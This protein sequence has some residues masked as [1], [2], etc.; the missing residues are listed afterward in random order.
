HK[1]LQNRAGENNCF[2]NVTVQ[3]LWHLDSF[4]AAVRGMEATADVREISIDDMITIVNSLFAQYEYYEGSAVPPTELRKRL[5]SMDPERYSLGGLADATEALYS[6]LSQ[7]HIDSCRHA[8]LPG[9]VVTENDECTPS[10]LAHSIFGGVFVEQFSCSACRATSEPQVMKRL[11]HYI[12]ADEVGSIFDAAPS[13]PSFSSV[14][15]Y[16]LRPVAHECPSRASTQRCQGEGKASLSCL[17]PPRVLAFCISWAEER[18]S[19]DKLS[20]FI[21]SIDIELSVSDVFPYG[22]FVDD[23]FHGRATHELCGL[24]CFYGMHYICF[25]RDSSSSS[26][27][28]LFDDARVRV[29]G[30]WGD[31]KE[32]C[33]RSRYQPVLLL[34]QLSQ[35]PSPQ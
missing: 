23:R 9:G 27:F 1:G 33:L 28:L 24:V 6:I 17:E 29:V 5:T 22:D 7:I 20:L 26:A 19:L 25:F 14:L 34:Y 11:L 8:T 32:D 10:C 4:R 12:Y 15:S 16:C 13:R 2:L 31:V 18:A 30:S 3:A 35:V 21:R